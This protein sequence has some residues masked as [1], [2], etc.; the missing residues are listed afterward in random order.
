MSRARQEKIRKLIQRYSSSQ[1]ANREPV[2]GMSG[3][4]RVIGILEEA[5]GSVLR[6]SPVS[7]PS[8]VALPTPPCSPASP[9]RPFSP[10]LKSILESVEQVLDAERSKQGPL[11]D[12]LLA[13]I[14][15]GGPQWTTETLREIA[16][17]GLV[18]GYFPTQTTSQRDSRSATNWVRCQNL[19]RS[20]SSDNGQTDVLPCLQN[21]LQYP[22]VRQFC[23][24]SQRI[25]DLIGCPVLRAAYR[26]HLVKSTRTANSQASYLLNMMATMEL[27]FLSV[28]VLHP[29]SCSALAAVVWELDHRECA[30]SGVC[31]IV[32]SRDHCGVGT[33]QL[34][35]TNR[36]LATTLAIGQMLASAYY[37]SHP[38]PLTWLQFGSKILVH[39]SFHANRLEENAEFN[40]IL[41]PQLSMLGCLIKRRS[42][43]ED[44]HRDG[45]CNLAEHL[46][47]LSG[48]DEKHLA[49]KYIRDF[50][51]SCPVFTG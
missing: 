36:E 13:T 50:S 12:R 44:R 20:I 45:L 43:E 3:W 38:H 32:D 37:L 30:N 22:S 17:I 5:L 9:W 27:I 24:E 51:R 39:P 21:R 40:Q 34:D 49:T 23:L 47:P 16:L 48:T 4:R 18:T 14:I 19:P 7:I 35:R 28:D 25:T 15:V 2:Q 1:I 29:P 46:I 8:P 11:G 33:P 26:Y 42:E 6:N 41:F 10:A 31:R